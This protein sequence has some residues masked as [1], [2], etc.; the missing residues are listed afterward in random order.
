MASINNKVN[1]IGNLGKDPEIKEFDSGKKMA[2]FPLATSEN[3]K[4]EK[5]EKH[6]E[7]TW[8]NIVLWNGLASVAEKYLTKGRQV[9]VEGRIVYREYEKDGDKKWI[10]EVIV[11]QMQ[12]LGTGKDKGVF[13]E[14]YEPVFMNRDAGKKATSE[15]LSS[16]DGKVRSELSMS[17]DGE[18]RYVYLLKGNL[19]RS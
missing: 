2:K 8:H 3:Y 12:M 14:K 18:L 17:D 15:Q 6:T 11:S 10:T 1:L 7:T 9:A 4:N 16:I 5:G 19:A 13:D